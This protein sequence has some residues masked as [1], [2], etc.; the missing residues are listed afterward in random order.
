MVNLDS[1]ARISG[2]TAGMCPSA[3]PRAEGEGARLPDLRAADDEQA[4][5]SLDVESSESTP[6]QTTSYVVE[7]YIA[8]GQ[9]QEEL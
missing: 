5:G 6:R 4:S 8:T 3:A 7:V 1:R 2:L 9:H